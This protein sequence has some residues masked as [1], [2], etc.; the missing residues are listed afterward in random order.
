MRQAVSS[1]TNEKELAGGREQLAKE[2]VVALALGSRFQPTPVHL[3][4][5]GA[6]NNFL[7]FDGERAQTP[8]AG[9]ARS[10]GL[11]S[12]ERRPRVA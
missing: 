10:E 5:R 11:R 12:P 2:N 6:D 4:P 1:E 8:N 7:L 3:Q 9:N